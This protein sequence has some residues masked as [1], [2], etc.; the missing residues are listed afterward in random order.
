MLSTLLLAALA[1]VPAALFLIIDGLAAWATRP[2]PATSVR[3]TVLVM[4]E[5]RAAA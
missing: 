5:R 2:R 3:R 4:Q 1:L